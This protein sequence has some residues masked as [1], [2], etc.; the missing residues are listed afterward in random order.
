MFEISTL[1]AITGLLA[2]G[3]AQIWYSI[4]LIIAVSLVWGATRHERLTEIIT[5]SIRSLIWVLTF[6]GIIFALIFCAGYLQ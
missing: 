3:A 2:L 6:M 5:Q 4:P 1:L